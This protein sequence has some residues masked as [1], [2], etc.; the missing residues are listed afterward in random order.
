MELKTGSY[1]GNA[2]DNRWINDVG[3]QPDLVVIKCDGA[4]KAVFRTSQMSNDSC[5]VFT[6]TASGNMTNAIQEFGSEGFQIGT[7]AHVNTNGDTYYWAAFRDNGAGDFHV[8]SYVGDDADDRNITGLGFTPTIVWIEGDTTQTAVWRIDENDGDDSLRFLEIVNPTDHIQDFIDDGF[9]VGTNARVNSNG[10]TYHYVAFCD[11]DDFIETGTYVGDGNDDRDITVGFE[12]N[13]VWVKGDT[14]KYSVLRIDTMDVGDSAP[15]HNLEPWANQIQSF[16]PDGFEVGTIARVNTD[17]VDYY[18]VA[19]KAG[20]SP[21]ARDVLWE[22]LIPEVTTNK[23]LNPSA[24]ESGNNAALGT[25]TVTLSTSRGKYGRRSYRVQPVA[26]NDGISLTLKALSNAVHYVTM[27]ICGTLPPAFDISLD[28][29]TY[30]TPELIRRLDDVWALYGLIISAAESNASTTLYIRQNGTGKGDF[31][32]DGIQVEE[33]VY[34]TTY[35]DGGQDGCEWLGTSH[36]STSQRSG[37][38]RAGGR[39]Y[40]L[41]DDYS[42]NIEQVVGAGVS[43]V[44]LGISEYSILPGGASGN[45]KVHPRSFT[46]IGILEE[47][48]WANLHSLKSDLYAV[49]KRN[50]VPKNEDGFQP[51]RLR[52]TGANVVKEIAAYYEDGLYGDLAAKNYSWERLAIRFLANDPFWYAI[53]EK[54]KT[55]PAFNQPA[56]SIQSIAGRFRGMKSYGTDTPWYYLNVNTAP[57]SGYVSCMTIGPDK[58]IYVGGSFKDWDGVVGRDYVAVYDPV[59]DSWA[60]LGNLT[61]FNV[62]VSTLAFGLDGI[63]YAGGSFSNCAGDANADYIAKWNGTAWS[64]VSGGGLPSV[65]SLAFGLDGTLYLGGVF[66]NWNTIANADYVVKWDGTAYAAL[67]TGMNGNVY[68]VA[69]GPDGTLYAGGAFTT[70]GGTSANRIAAWDGSSWSALGSG[71]DAAVREISIDK[72]GTLYAGGS[73]TTAGGNT[74]NK[75][76]VWNGVFWSDL[77]TGVSGGD[78]YAIAAGPDSIIYVGGSFD[79]AGSSS[80]A[81]AGSPIRWDGATWSRAD[82]HLP[83]TVVCRTIAIEDADPTVPAN[84]GIYIGNSGVSGTSTLPVATTVNNSGTESA[85]PRIIIV[86]DAAATTADLFQIKNETT[87]KILMFDYTLQAGEEV[88]IDLRPKNKSIVSSFYGPIPKALIAG[89]NFGTFTLQPGDNVITNLIDPTAGT[90]LSEIDMYM[91]WQEVYSSQD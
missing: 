31:Y 72:D 83:G 80:M 49:L 14:A 6:T 21:I 24:E 10:I 7:A 9:Q 62:T 37:Q 23:V 38:D 12:P 30:A 87:G 32:V 48:S 78:V 47:T 13:M 66:T 85:Y 17:G 35:C 63:L 69:V 28:N 2:T 3:F 60:T 64:A 91:I 42:L 50:A 44:T 1:I 68:V 11:A 39:V 61:D 51:T 52:Y 77:D 75:V 88:T 76:A 71:V 41:E 89:S 8:G 22:I 59:D 20:S 26:D 55:L 18:W 84:Y 86:M 90:I 74:V 53:G 33:K 65:H 19:W 56:T 5:A 36:A 46:L 43:P 67:G 40:D 15:H 27:R 79:Y 70:A 82:I 81:C 4:T 73:F 54:S 57:S 45:I 29:A 25:A 34:W 16:E 58:K